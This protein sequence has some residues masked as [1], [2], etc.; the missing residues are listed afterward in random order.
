MKIIVGLGNIG[1]EYSNTRHNIGFKMLDILSNKYNIKYKLDK[2][3]N[4]YIAEKIINGENIILVKPTTY[5]NNSG[6]CVKKIVE[7]YNIELKDLFIIY[8]DMDMELSKVK[9]KSKGSAGGHNGIKS[10][11]ENIGNKDYGRLKIGIGH[12][13]K[14][15]VVDYVLGEFNKQE[16]KILI[17]EEIKILDIIEWFIIDKSFEMI[18]NKFN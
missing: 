8:D 11:I 13:E 2:K 16:E 5:M 14:N 17:K 7:K 12:P 3:N 10:I 1:K 15:N 4:G 6:I 9:V 18:M